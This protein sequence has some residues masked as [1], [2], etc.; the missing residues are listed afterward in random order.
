MQHDFGCIFGTLEKIS[1]KRKSQIPSAC[2]HH[3]VAALYTW[4][5]FASSRVSVTVPVPPSSSCRRTFIL[6]AY[7]VFIRNHHVPMLPCSFFFKKN[8]TSKYV[9][10]CVSK[11][12]QACYTAQEGRFRVSIKTC[13][14]IV[15]PMFYMEFYRFSAGRPIFSSSLTQPGRT[16]HQY[17]ASQ[18]RYPASLAKMMTLYMML[19]EIDQGRMK[20]DTKIRVSRKQHNRRANWGCAIVRP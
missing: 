7:S 9:S 15:K 17:R 16:L 18:Q 19:E 20:P 14:R 5:A 3:S 8:N 1:V 10:G 12:N 11:A 4:Q 13:N 2:N 6:H